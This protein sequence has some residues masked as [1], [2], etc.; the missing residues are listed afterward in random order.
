V[1]GVLAD[2]PSY[3]SS[4]ALFDIDTPTPPRP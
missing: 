4:V 1:E 3:R 2:A